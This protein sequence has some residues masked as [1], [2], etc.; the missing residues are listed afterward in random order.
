MPPCAVLERC[1]LAVQG[2]VAIEIPSVRLS[3]ASIVTKRFELRSQS[4]HCRIATWY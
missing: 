1:S 3:H 2:F 4:L